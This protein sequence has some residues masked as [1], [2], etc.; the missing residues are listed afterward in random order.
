MNSIHVPCPHCKVVCSVPE[1]HIGKSLLCGQCKKGFLASAPA[2]AAEPELAEVLPADEPVAAKSTEAN[3]G[4]QTSPNRVPPPASS[5]HAPTGDQPLPKPGLSPLVW[6]LGGAALVFVGLGVAVTLGLAVWFLLPT[7]KTQE[8]ADGNRPQPNANAPP[9]NAPAPVEPKDPPPVVGAGDEEAVEA[10][11]IKRCP[12]KQDSEERELPSTVHDMI[13]GGGGRFIILTLPKTQK[14]AI[15]DVNEAKIV[16]YLPMAESGAIVAAGMDKLFVCLPNAGV[17]QRWSLRTFERDLLVPSPL[18]GNLTAACMGWASDGPLLLTSAT[19]DRFARGGESLFVSARTLKPLELRTRQEPFRATLGVDAR[20]S[21][22]GTMFTCMDG[23]RSVH[24]YVI[25]DG[26]VTHHRGDTSSFISAPA[27]DGS[28]ICTMIGVYTPEMTEVFPKT[29]QHGIITSPFVASKQGRMFMRIGE[30]GHNE[31]KPLNF[32]FYGNDRP[33]ATMPNFTEFNSQANTYGDE[34]RRLSAD[35][36]Y[37][38][39]PDAEVIVAL[40]AANDRLILKRFDMRALLE[41]SG[42]DY[43]L[44]TS[45]P[46]RLA[47]RGQTYR[48]D[49]AILSKKGGLQCKIESGPAGMQTTPDGKLTWDVPADYREGKADVIMTVADSGGQQVFHNFKV[50]VKNKAAGP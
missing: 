10:F 16:K 12:I 46:P 22:D 8:V 43:L 30:G 11:E 42:T 13:L 32:F 48:Y 20:P 28:F 4:L 24:V 26:L 49:L 34:A 50:V 1:T 41:K 27:A 38:L 33:I 17:I 3:P 37:L 47:V 14:I 23:S 44:V 19:S 2:A 18:K 6:I 25:R 7:G 45:Q 31:V 35:R 15:F 39:L 36:R 5:A 21:G 29:P 40:L 9:A